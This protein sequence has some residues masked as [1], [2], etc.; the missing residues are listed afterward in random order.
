[1]YHVV[2]DGYRA[3]EFDSLAD[4]EEYCSEYDNGVQ[5]SIFE[6]EQRLIK[7]EFKQ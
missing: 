1:M 2:R 5:W 6:V 7:K 4:A 3:A